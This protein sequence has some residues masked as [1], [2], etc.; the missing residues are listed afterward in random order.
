MQDELL[1]S[2]ITGFLETTKYPLGAK[3]HGFAITVLSD[4]FNYLDTI[5]YTI[6]PKTNESTGN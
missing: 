1:Y 5:D 4:F 2:L 6:I 3:D